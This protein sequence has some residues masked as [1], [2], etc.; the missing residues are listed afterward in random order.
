MLAVMQSIS[1]RR[2]E[3][4]LAMAVAKALGNNGLTFPQ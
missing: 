4:Q 1:M 3:K 2:G